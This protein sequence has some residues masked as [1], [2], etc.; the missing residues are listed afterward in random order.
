MTLNQ[1]LFHPATLTT[2][3]L[4]GAALVWLAIGRRLHFSR[5]RTTANGYAVIDALLTLDGRRAPTE[6]RCYFTVRRR[7]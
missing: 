3:A 4:C 6:I 1:F 5:T 7:V 2:A